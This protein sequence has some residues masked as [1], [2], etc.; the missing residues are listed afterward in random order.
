MVLAVFDGIVFASV[1]LAIIYLLLL[2]FV[3][4]QLYIVHSEDIEKLILIYAQNPRVV[5][6]NDLPSTLNTKKL[7]IMTCLLSCLLRFMSFSSMAVCELSAIK[8]SEVMNGQGNFDDSTTGTSDFYKKAMLVLFD[9]PDFCII[10]AYL[11]LI[12]VWAEAYLQVYYN[13]NYIYISSC[14]IYCFQ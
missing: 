11:L 14:E 10:S 1:F 9:F 13:N 2:F 6:R 7:F 4:R 5:N 8:Y 12:V 3:A